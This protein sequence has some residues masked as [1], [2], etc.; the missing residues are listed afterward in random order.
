MNHRA[1]IVFLLLVL[2]IFSVRGQSPL[3]AE[4]KELHPRESAVKLRLLS[5]PFSRVY[6]DRACKEDKVMQSPPAFAVFHVI[7]VPS[8]GSSRVYEVADSTGL[9][10]GYM[11]EED[12]IP[13]K[14]ALCLQFEHV[15]NRNPVLMFGSKPPLKELVT[16][17]EI[18]RK[19]K[20]SDLYSA[21]EGL[22]EDKVL[23]NGFPVISME[24]RRM[25]EGSAGNYLMPI[26]D[27][28]MVEMGED[29]ARLLQVAIAA[30]KAT[31]R[32]ATTLEDKEFA[33]AA[34][35]KTDAADANAA[36]VEIIYC[37]D[38]TSSM[39]PYVDIC[40]AVASQVS[41]ALGGNPA[42]RQRVRFGLW[43]YRDHG[44]EGRE[45]THKNFT[46]QLLP[47]E[48]LE[49]ALSQA[50]AS[51]DKTGDYE[52]DMLG[53]VQ[54]AVKEWAGPADRAIRILIVFGDA[55]GHD[56]P[57][58]ARNGSRY[59]VFQ[60]KNEV[61]AAKV[62]LYAI[63]IKDP[64]FT[65]YHSSAENQFRALTGGSGLTVGEAYWGVRGDSSQD[66]QTA[67]QS[68]FTALNNLIN[69][70][71][72]LIEEGEQRKNEGP[73]AP[74]KLTPDIIANDL[75]RAALVDWIG[76]NSK[77]TPTPNDI[78]AWISE[79][80]L[81]NGE[82]S[83]KATVLISK[84][85]LDQLTGALKLVLEAG[86]RGRITGQDFFASLQSVA[87]TAVRDP[88]KLKNATSLKEAGLIPEFISGLP[89]KS[90]IMNLSNDLWASWPPT[91]QQKFLEEVQNRVTLYEDIHN[92]P[93]RWSD[94][95]GKSADDDKVASIPLDQL[96]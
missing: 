22:S 13:W 39:Q 75:F 62:Y 10:L 7:Q 94:L 5:K 37:F 46:P 76:R 70:A 16:G 82:P 6:A 40:R 55:P 38:L 89:Y 79:K 72:Q 15:G 59:D 49:S 60:L 44:E 74:E 18:R 96:P 50:R 85:Q 88:T 90:R 87:A 61:T 73:I 17:D 19:A 31:P 8:S 68:L 95:D 78:T 77:D 43:G 4:R 2:G 86:Q 54:K 69:N 21:V 58:D 26:V 92:S 34:N 91:Q 30:N 14:Q 3:V 80:D 71:S 84:V 93:A 57:G 47:L 53:G 23:P 24:P 52:E 20:A 1:L 11:K 83:V 56:Q 45:F 51:T 29:E 64:R 65:K 41:Q 25:M 32:G 12:V 33:K 42:V 63:H 81:M 27:H 28:D 36:P 67:A 48:Q 35:Q 9:S 66:F